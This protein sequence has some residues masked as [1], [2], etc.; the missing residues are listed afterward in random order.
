MRFSA[1]CFTFVFKFDPFS[2]SIDSKIYLA[3]FA[4]TV[5]CAI[6]ITIRHLFEKPAQSIA[7]GF[8]KPIWKKRDEEDELEEPRKARRRKADRF[9]DDEEYE[10]A[11]P[12]RKAFERRRAAAEVDYEI[13]EYKRLPA[14]VGSYEGSVSEKPRIYFSAVEEDVLVHE[15]SDR[16]EVFRVVNGKVVPDRVEYKNYEA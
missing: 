12:V 10:E 4:G 7:E 13:S 9:F 5:L 6:L 16:F 8:K 3:G 1:E 15:Y 11:P 14:S 2:G